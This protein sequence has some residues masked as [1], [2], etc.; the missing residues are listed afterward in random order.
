MVAAGTL[1]TAAAGT[2]GIPCTTDY[3]IIP[4]PVGSTT[5]RFCGAGLGAVTSKNAQIF[6]LKNIV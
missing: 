4:S 6:S 1:G 5:D 3:L 2:A